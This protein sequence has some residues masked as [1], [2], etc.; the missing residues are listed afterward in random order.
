RPFA[1]RSEGCTRGAGR[2]PRWCRLAELGAPPEAVVAKPVEEAAALIGHHA[3][4]LGGE[5]WGAE[6]RTILPC[7]VESRPAADLDRP[8]SSASPSLLRGPTRRPTRCNARP[9]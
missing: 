5:P 1:R 9:S 8:A 6:V 3:G 7:D 4:K 2:P